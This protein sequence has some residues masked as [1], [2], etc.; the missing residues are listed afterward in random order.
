VKDIITIQV[1][2]TAAVARAIMA[3]GMRR[4]WKRPRRTGQKKKQQ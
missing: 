2:D 1:V 4:T 3:E